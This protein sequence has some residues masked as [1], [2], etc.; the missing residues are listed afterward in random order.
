ML[1]FNEFKHISAFAKFPKRRGWRKIYI[2]IVFKVTAGQTGADPGISKGGGGGGPGAIELLGSGDCCV[3]PLHI[4]YIF[5][6]RVKKY[7]YMINIAYW[8][9]IN[10]HK[11]KHLQT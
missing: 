2:T 5:V 10:N 8:Q 3:D 11:R 4:P 9:R 6:A 1:Y 7:I